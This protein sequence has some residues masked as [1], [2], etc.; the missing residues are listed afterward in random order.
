[1]LLPHLKL[2]VLVFPNNTQHGTWWGRSWGHFY[3][4]VQTLPVNFGFLFW[5]YERLSAYIKSY[6]RNYSRENSKLIFPP[7]CGYPLHFAYVFFPC[8][9]YSLVNLISKVLSTLV[10]LDCSLWPLCFSALAPVL[11]KQECPWPPSCC[12]TRK[13]HLISIFYWPVI[14]RCCFMEWEKEQ[15]LLWYLAYLLAIY[16]S[17]LPINK[18][19]TM[20][21]SL[22]L[23]EGPSF[24]PAWPL[25]WPLAGLIEWTWSGVLLLYQVWNVECFECM[26]NRWLAESD[27]STAWSTEHPWVYT[28][29]A[30]SMPGSTLYQI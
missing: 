20:I 7:T 4:R 14:A 2:A 1:M 23:I 17:T 16:R 25:L 3:H 5:E 26:E 30:L 27:A 12:V 21:V 22:Q 19:I 15:V 9:F 29:R 18:L 6:A 10:M 11:E 13:Q 28:D 24:V 8:L